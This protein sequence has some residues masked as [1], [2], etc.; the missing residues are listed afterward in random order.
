[1][2]QK[3]EQ[4][5]R[6]L[7]LWPLSAREVERGTANRQTK[8]KART[9]STQNKESLVVGDAVYR[10]GNV[11]NRNPYQE[12]DCSANKCP[13]LIGASCFFILLD[14]VVL[15]YLPFPACFLSMKLETKRL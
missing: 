12:A 2:A 11:G 6:D 7:I 9:T 5:R 13:M 14:L 4:R 3:C 1:M 15:L 10:D 8:W